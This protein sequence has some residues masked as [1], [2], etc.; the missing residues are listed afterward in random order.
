MPPGLH[1]SA[2]H[3]C[4]KLGG[5]FK[6]RR[7]KA[8]YG[9]TDSSCERVAAHH[10]ACPESR[11]DR[12]SESHTGFSGASADEKRVNRDSQGPHLPCAAP[13]CRGDGEGR[14]SGETQ[15]TLCRGRAVPDCRTSCFFRQPRPSN[16]L[17]QYGLPAPIQY[18]LHP[19]SHNF[20]ARSL[21]TWDCALS[22][23]LRRLAGTACAIMSLQPPISRGS[24]ACRSTPTHGIY[25]FV[26]SCP[27]AGR[28]FSDESEAKPDS[29]MH[30]P[31]AS[32]ATSLCLVFSSAAP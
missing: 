19:H 32:S 9:S 17:L 31:R 11:R 10:A 25:T 20:L 5:H 28:V 8:W 26:Q 24:D 14:L 6:L 30:M 29:C 21:F 2:R 23:T 13:D 27:H 7:G 1:V 4:R 22:P 15:Y 16:P 3:K 12:R 18:A